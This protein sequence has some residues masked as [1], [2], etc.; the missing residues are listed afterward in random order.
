MRSLIAAAVLAIA[1][2]LAAA[3]PASA[4]ATLL[5]A[6]PGIDSAVPTAPAAILLVFDNPVTAGNSAIT[7]V[8]ANGAEIR[9]GVPQLESRSTT[10]RAAT[11]SHL[12][13][14]AYTVDWVVTAGD[15]DTMQGQYHFAIGTT[16]GLGA[17]SVQATAGAAPTGLLRW[18]LFAGLA[19]S[20]GG[21]VGARLARQTRPNT[22]AAAAGDPEP[23]LTAGAALSSIAALGILLAVVGNGSLTGGLDN[24]SPSMSTGPGLLAVAELVAGV[25]SLIC[26]RLRLRL[27]GATGLV[28]VTIAEGLRAHPHTE[29]PFWGAALVTIHLLV[30]A[31]WIG[32]LVHVLRVARSRHRQGVGTAGL[33]RRYARMAAWLLAAVVATGILNGLAVAP[34]RLLADTLT[35]TSY[36]HWL[37]VKLGL[38]LAAVSC[39]AVAR[40][41]LLARP[42]GRQPSQAA[43]V[44]AMALVAVLGVSAALTV[45]APPADPNAPLPFAPPANGPVFSAGTRAGWVGIGV[46][47]SEGQLLVRLTAPEL[48]GDGD[49][50]S[51]YGLNGNLTTAGESRKV[52]FRGCGT[53]CFVAP[54][55]W[56]RGMDTV[57][58]HADHSGDLAGGTAAV[59]IAW[60]PRPATAVLQ[61]IVAAMRDVSQLEVHERV[62]SDANNQPVAPTLL[63]LSGREFINS[64]PYS[65]GRA[66]TTSLVNQSGDQTTISLGYSGDQTYVLLTADAAG[67]L[68]HEIL[69]GPNHLVERTF[70][71]P[72][73]G[74]D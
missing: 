55:T 2:L 67:R 1:A 68:V 36:G 62:T 46:S 41:R 56:A 48:A 47:A 21:L 24:L 12:R 27:A 57:T 50:S 34:L 44:E 59:A 61:K 69:T 18:L 63:H 45:S 38:V 40:W 29:W 42:T 3:S 37:D 6:S 19:L 60:P 11:T 5:F 52:T 49:T 20:L 25:L 54:A 15:G 23:A 65:S 53:G 22:G 10:L 28:A 33:V 51:D 30:A 70:V 8:D 64:D 17:P 7:L 13:P 66:T 72:E 9:L 31:V 73:A 39:A 43:R 58:L 14:G 74:A 4:H 16:A 26:F 32:A 71:Y 35:H